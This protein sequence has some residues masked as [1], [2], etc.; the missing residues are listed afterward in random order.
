MAHVVIL[1]TDG[2]IEALDFP[3]RGLLQSI[4]RAIGCDTIDCVTLR[5]GRVMCVDDNGYDCRAEQRPYG[6][7]VVPVRALKPVNA[8][9]TALYHSV[10]GPG[11]THQIVGDVAI[12]NDEDF[13]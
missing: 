8:Q 7:E 4:Y 13:A 11:T 5:D 9:A 12:A 1:R 3:K 6:V 2:T 10:C